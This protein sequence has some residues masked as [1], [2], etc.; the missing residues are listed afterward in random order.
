MKIKYWLSGALWLFAS[1]AWAATPNPHTLLQ[2][3]TDQTIAQLKQQKPNLQQQPQIADRII[4]N[5]LLPHIAKTIMARNVLGRT[6][7]LNA[8][9]S[10]RKRFVNEFTTALIRTYATALTEY[11]HET[12]R[13]LPIRG[14]YQ[15]KKRLQVESYIIRPNGPRIAMSYRVLL[16]NNAWRIY[17]ISIDNI[18]VTKSFQAQFVGQIQQYGMKK[19]LVDLHAHNAKVTK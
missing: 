17:D 6:L 1:V 2:R 15:G 11:D 14:G 4:R 10:Q 5:T 9:S 12:V 19:F 18:S 3:I 7:W 8:T 16:R 13:F